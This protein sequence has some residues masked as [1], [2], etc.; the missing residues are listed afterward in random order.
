MICVFG[1][2]FVYIHSIPKNTLLLVKN[3]YISIKIDC[4]L[5]YWSLRRPNLCDVIMCSL[6]FGSGRR[7]VFLRLIDKGPMPGLFEIACQRALGKIPSRESHA[8]GGPRRTT[9]IQN[10]T[11]ICTTSRHAVRLGSCLFELAIP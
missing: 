2:I 7:S 6:Q 4:H 10:S 11:I 3:L 9:R 5:L 1:T 8:F